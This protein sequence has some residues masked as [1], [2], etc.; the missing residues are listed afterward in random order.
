MPRKFC[1]IISDGQITMLL[2]LSNYPEHN[3]Q[4]EIFYPDCDIQIHQSTFLIPV[5]Y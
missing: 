2:Y 3:P 1:T 5:F 4:E